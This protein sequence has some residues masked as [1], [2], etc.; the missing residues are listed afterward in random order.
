MATTVAVRVEDAIDEVSEL[1][2]D[3]FAGWRA[4]TLVERGGR[5]G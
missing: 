2:A 1:G 4:T 3:M 5:V